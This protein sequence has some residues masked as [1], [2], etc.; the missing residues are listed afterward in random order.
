MATRRSEDEPDV[1]GVRR[2]PEDRLEIV[3]ALIDG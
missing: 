1:S 3:K 2:L